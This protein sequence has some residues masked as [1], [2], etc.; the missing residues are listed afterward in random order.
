MLYVQ[1]NMQL[2]LRGCLYG[3]EDGTILHGMV[4]IKPYLYKNCVVFIWSRDVFHSVPA[5]RDRSWKRG[6][7]HSP[8]F[9]HCV[10]TILTQRSLLT[11]WQLFEIEFLKCSRTN[12][13]NFFPT[14]FALNNKRNLNKVVWKVESCIYRLKS[15]KAAFLM[16]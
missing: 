8:D 2:L 12:A 15:I 9:N 7:P 10:S 6:K 1:H 11:F 4:S 5:R 13:Q 14:F 3:K 16:F